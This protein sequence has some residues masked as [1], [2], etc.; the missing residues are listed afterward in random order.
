MSVTWSFSGFTPALISFRN[1]SL[2]VAVWDCPDSEP[3]LAALR[4]GHRVLISGRT[5]YLFTGKA[6]D[7][8][9]LEFNCRGALQRLSRV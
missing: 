2:D 6:F 5:F 3:L 4:F 9:D 8:L 1:R 7:F